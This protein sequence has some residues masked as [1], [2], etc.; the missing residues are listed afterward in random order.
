MDFTVRKMTEVDLPAVAEIEAGVF[1]DWYRIYRREPEPLAERTL[2][3]LR[4]ATSLDPDGNHVAVAEDGALVGFILSRSWG[5]VGWFGTFGVPT[6]FHGLGIGTALVD[7]AVEYLSSKCAIVGLETMPE[8]GANMGLY[9]KAGFVPTYPTLVME[10][11]LIHEAERFRSAF[12]DELR[13]WGEMGRMERGKALAGIREVSDALTPGLD[14]CREVTALNEHELGKTFV[15]R[16]QSGRVDGFAILR[17]APFRREDNSGRA[18]IHALGIRPEADPGT[19]LLDLLRQVW[20][21][22][23]ALGL[24]RAAVGLNARHQ[25]GLALLKENGFRVVRAGIRM[26]RLPVGGEMF[27]PTESIELSRWAG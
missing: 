17:T 24:S 5:S 15:S 6:Q 12:K 20:A 19:V 1:T 7:T 2:P 4:Y 27:S 18:Y 3:E 21:A 22:A 13:P 11:S 10:L 9:A 8:S 25:S 16:G 26:V 23:T 14:F